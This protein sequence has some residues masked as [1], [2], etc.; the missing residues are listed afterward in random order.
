MHLEMFADFICIPPYASALRSMGKLFTLVHSVQ[1]NIDNCNCIRRRMSLLVPVLAAV[2]KRHSVAG[3]GA[4]SSAAADATLF[5]G[6]LIDKL[7]VQVQAFCDAG[8]VTRCVRTSSFK[9]NV[10]RLQVEIDK[11]LEVLK[12]ALSADQSRL[13][14]VVMEQSAALQLSVDAKLDVLSE[15]LRGTSMSVAELKGLVAE[16][17]TS[18]AEAMLKGVDV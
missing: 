4:L 8:F 15:A 16:R 12:T 5:I 2:Y 14:D 18:V 17:M 10:D 11:Q 7:G 3:E 6:E 9:A 13:M 1:F